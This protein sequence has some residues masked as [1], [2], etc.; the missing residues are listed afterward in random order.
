MIYTR[1]NL[2]S[3]NIWGLLYTILCNITSQKRA[4]DR[5]LIVFTTK[6]E[7]IGLQLYL[8][9]SVAKGFELVGENA[10]RHLEWRASLG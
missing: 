10:G 4:L 6:Q 2:S 5:F 8:F 9:A 7:I 3:F 1:L